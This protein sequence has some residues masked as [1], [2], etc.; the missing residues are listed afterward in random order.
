MKIKADGY[1]YFRCNENQKDDTLT[2]NEST[3]GFVLDF[4]NVGDPS[5][6]FGSFF[7]SIID[8]DTAFCDS[9]FIEK[10]SNARL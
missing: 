4:M 7:I 8:C 1:C 3:T 9:I 2:H 10:R 6:G 5:G